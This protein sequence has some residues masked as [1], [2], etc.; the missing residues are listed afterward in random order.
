MSAAEL[1]I[2]SV[3]RAGGRGRLPRSAHQSE[4]LSRH[5]APLS[6]YKRTREDVR[7]AQQDCAVEMMRTANIL[8]GSLAS[9]RSMALR[10]SACSVYRLQP[11]RL[12]EP[13]TDR[14]GKDFCR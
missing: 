10:L 12:D 2:G 8:V 13:C 5:N 1:R 4:E 7:S 9:R 6:A 11:T 14:S 3:S